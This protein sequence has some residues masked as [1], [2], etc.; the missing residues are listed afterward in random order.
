MSVEYSPVPQGHKA[1]VNSHVH[2]NKTSKANASSDET[3]GGFSSLLNFLSAPVDDQ[4]SEDAVANS[5][6]TCMSVSPAGQPTVTATSGLSDTLSASNLNGMQPEAGVLTSGLTKGGASLVMGGDGSERFPQDVNAVAPAASMKVSGLASSAVKKAQQSGSSESLATEVKPSPFDFLQPLQQSAVMGQDLAAAEAFEASPIHALLA[7]RGSHLSV[8]S[9]E[10]K[11]DL[12]SVAAPTVLATAMNVPSDA[13]MTLLNGSDLGRPHLRLGNKSGLG[14]SGSNGFE[15]VFGQVMTASSRS[16][17][18]FEISPPSALV[19]DTA[20]AETVTYWASHG[21]Q[22]AILTLDDFGESPVEVSISLQGDQ[23]QIDFRT[24][25]LGV[26]QI[27]ENATAQLQDLLSSQGLQLA[28]V[29]V[30]HS[31]A[32]NQNGGD[33]RQLPEAQQIGLVKT[34][35]IDVAV[36]RTGN[37][38]VGR[39]LDLFV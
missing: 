1:S 13:V 36:T 20:V 21:V 32:G 7:Q 5:L 24:D 3:G 35:A 22:S 8:T 30:S 37:P 10:I 38:A 29:S 31:G 18:V 34:D 4:G 14:Q 27:L 16:D 28:G 19:A 17:A 15:G 23:T 26:R 12:Q 11:Q 9:H 6:L 2:G 33:R 25:Q 39:S